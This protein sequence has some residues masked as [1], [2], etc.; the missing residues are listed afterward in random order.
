MVAIKGKSGIYFRTEEH[1]KNISKSKKGEKNPMW[2]KN[3]SIESKRKI[4]EGNKGKRPKTSE[5]MKRLY[6]EGI[7]NAKGRK[8]TLGK[9]WKLSNEIKEKLRKIASNRNYLH[10]EESKR[11]ISEARKKQILPKKDSLI[12]VKIQNFLKQLGIE[13]FTH[14]YMHIE[15]GYQCDIFIPSKNLL[16]ECFGDYWHK[17]PYGNLLDSLR[18]QELREKGYRV[19][20]FWEREINVMEL[21]DLKNKLK[22]G[23]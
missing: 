22:Y 1:R 4:S 11:K 19:L 12:E 2:G 8:Q 20:V 15:H 17:I 6:K 18:C 16:I 5:T 7:L 3:H 14:Q 9:H 23:R 13:F 21:N 10:S